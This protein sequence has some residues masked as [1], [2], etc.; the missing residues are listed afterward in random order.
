[1]GEPASAFEVHHSMKKKPTRKK[2]TKT[3]T[4]IE[5]F[6]PYPNPHKLPIS[7]AAVAGDFMYTWGFG[8]VFDVKNPEPGM[9]EVFEHI[10]GLL[11]QKNLG[12]E[13]VVKT[14]VLL[15]PAQ[16]FKIYSKVYQEYFKAPYPCRT[17]I[18]VASDS[19][20]LEIDVVA[21]LGGPQSEV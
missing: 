11:A 2:T 3:K 14:T 21:Y 5:F 7:Q 9:R 16:F 17:T 6:S 19:A 12:F 8:A 13:H 1:M 18:P 10:Q 4:G 15:A 20:F